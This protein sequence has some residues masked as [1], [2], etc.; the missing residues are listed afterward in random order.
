MTTEIRAYGDGQ[1]IVVYTDEQPIVAQLSRFTSLSRIVWYEHMQ[2]GRMADWPTIAA[3]LYFPKE[4][5]ARLRRDLG[6]EHEA[7]VASK[8]KPR[9]TVKSITGESKRGKWPRKPKQ[10]APITVG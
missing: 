7:R 4:Q 2:K 1:Q 9:L 5:E 10:N 8:R 6:L 3:D